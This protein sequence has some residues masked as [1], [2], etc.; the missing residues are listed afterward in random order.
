MVG[1]SLA[2]NHLSRLARQGRG[3]DTELAHVNPQ[4]KAMLKSMGGSG[5]I[6]PNTGLREYQIPAYVPGGFGAGASALSSITSIGSAT[7][8]AT[9]A[10]TTVATTGSSLLAGAGSVLGS[11]ASAAGPI[12]LVLGAIQGISASRKERE[13]GQRQLNML[14]QQSKALDKSSKALVKGKESKE[15]SVATDFVSASTTLGTKEGIAERGIKK[16]LE[17]TGLVKSSGISD[18]EFQTEQ[19]FDIG[20]KDLYTQLDKSMGEV[21]GWF[22]GEQGKLGA[23]RRSIEAQKKQAKAMTESYWMGIV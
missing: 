20:K 14:N 4:E 10:A 15:E 11:I 22:A 1:S 16:G 21:S 19:E 3:G 13:E 17:S 6:N 23:E 2:Q 12:G 8:A 5:G 18:I 7:T 9:T